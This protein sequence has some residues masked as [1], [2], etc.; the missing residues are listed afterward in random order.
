MF[1]EIEIHQND[2]NYFDELWIKNKIGESPHY[3]TISSI[4][5]KKYP[6]EDIITEIENSL[7]R[8]KINPNFPYP[9]YLLHPQAGCTRNHAG[10]PLQMRTLPIIYSIE[11][12]PKHYI[13]KNRI[14]TNREKA[15]LQK[16]SMLRQMLRSFSYDEIFDQIIKIKKMQRDYSQVLRE[17]D[18]Y[19][20]ILKK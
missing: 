4:L 10:H 13:F 7:H 9:L 5:L 15:I 18:Y 3:I 14:P 6:I 1:R 2:Q 16:V 19:Q 12:L 8:C 17:I 11:N 20:Q